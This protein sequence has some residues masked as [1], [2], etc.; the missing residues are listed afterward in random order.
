MNTS[1]KPEPSTYL[2]LRLG[3]RPL[4]VSVYWL[5]RSLLPG[6]ARAS[7][8]MPALPW[9]GGWF[10]WHWKRFAMFIQRE[11]GLPCPSKE[12]GHLSSAVP[13]WPLGGHFVWG[14]SLCTHFVHTLYEVRTVYSRFLI[15][16][17]QAL[18]ENA[19]RWMN[20]SR[21]LSEQPPQKRQH[22][23]PG[24]NVGCLTRVWD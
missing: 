23:E 5:A 15:W 2:T 16:P 8:D 4:S 10:Q 24:H 19:P 20:H 1:E 13:E 18:P 9:E 14:Q 12:K 21:T 17:N 6:T 11:R 3:F 22:S 7:A